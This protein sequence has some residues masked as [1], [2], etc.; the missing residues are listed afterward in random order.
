MHLDIIYGSAGCLL[1]LLSLHA[2][3]PSPRTLEV[4]VQ[5]GDRLLATAQPMPE[6]VAWRTLPGQ[7]PLGGFSHGTAGFAFSLLQLADRS[8]RQRF[9]D[10][11]LRALAYD[12]SLFVPELGSWED[13]RVFAEKPGVTRSSQTSMV[14]WCHGAAGIGLGRLGALHQLDDGRIRDEIDA[15]LAATIDFGFAINH[16]LCHGALGNI[17][18]LLTAARLL[19]RPE[20]RAALE[21]A[22]AAVVGSIEANGPVTGVPLGVETPGF[23]TGLAGIGY[24]LLRLAEPDKI[25]SVL[26]LAPP[27]S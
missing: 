2:V 20:D 19:G 23:M 12:R 17:E 6:G 14:A 26:L 27:P 8:G 13:I 7:P 18:L 15:A 5:C 11:A 1:V 16:S 25:P 21:A 9:R 24:E 3:H 22:T 4:A 10:C